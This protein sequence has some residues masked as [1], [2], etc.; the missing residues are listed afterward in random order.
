MW[1]RGPRGN[2][3]VCWALCQLSVTSA[4]ANK[5]TGP[6]WKLIPGWT[7]CV[8]SRTLWVSPTNSPVRL[9]I[10]PTAANPTDFFSQRFWGFIYPHWNP[11]LQSNSFPNCSSRFIC[12]Q[13][14]DCSLCQLPS[15]PFQCCSLCF[16]VHPLC[17]AAHLCPS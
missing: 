15:C 2:N 10:S 16:A 8:H 4:T 5:Q 9:G 1:G 11:G 12:T 13:I 14:W 7:G 3:S 17:P 6:F